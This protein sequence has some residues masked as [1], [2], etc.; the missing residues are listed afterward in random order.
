MKC[1]LIAVTSL[2][3]YKKIW[4]PV[5]LIFTLAQKSDHIEKRIHNSITKSWL[6]L[7]WASSIKFTSVYLIFCQSLSMA[8]YHNVNY[9]IRKLME[10]FLLFFVLETSQSL[11]TFE[12][13][14]NW[15]KKKPTTRPWLIVTNSKC[16]FPKSLTLM[17]FSYFDIF[18]VNLTI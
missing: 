18:W 15:P 6:L 13:L 16:E 5:N 9:L 3:T 10:N 14:I 1:L 11:S 17:T 12:Y 7:S 8:F 4:S 2:E